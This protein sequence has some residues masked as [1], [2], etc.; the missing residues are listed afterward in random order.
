[1][2]SIFSDPWTAA[3]NKILSKQNFILAKNIRLQGL[4]LLVYSQMKHVTHLREIEAQF[5]RTGLG[6]M[7]VRITFII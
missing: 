6:G 7:W 5:T 3:F 1:M 4:L 2:D